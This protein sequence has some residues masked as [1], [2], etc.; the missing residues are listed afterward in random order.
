M[1]GHNRQPAFRQQKVDIGDAAMLRIFNRDDRAGSAAILDRLECVFKA[2]A[3]QRQAGRIAFQR[4]AVAIAARR[5]LKGEFSRVAQD[6]IDVGSSAGGARAMTVLHEGD[7]AEHIEHLD[8][9]ITG[10]LA[11]AKLF[12]HRRVHL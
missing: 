8:R 9:E 7:R 3:R 4:S 10:C 2:E 1:L 5:A 6:I 11:P 12:E